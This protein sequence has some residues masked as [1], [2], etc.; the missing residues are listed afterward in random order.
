MKHSPNPITIVTAQACAPSRER[1]RQL[2]AGSARYQLLGEADSGPELLRQVLL[3]Q[4]HLVVTDVQLPAGGGVDTCRTILR[5]SPA[6]GILA[7][8]PH[9]GSGKVLEAVQAGVS[10]CLQKDRL[11]AELLPALE[12]VA[13]G[14]LYGNT[15]VEHVLQQLHHTRPDPPPETRFSPH[16]LQVIS[17]ICRQLTG[18]EIARALS[19]SLRVVEDIHARLQEKTGARSGVGIALYA[20]R[21]GLVRVD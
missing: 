9:D 19:L 8:C 21:Q 11:A 14:R 13:E 17:L 16:E 5:L 4:P 12:A 2:I 20:L 6:T 15:L 18:H 3:H 1:L 10:A 7:L